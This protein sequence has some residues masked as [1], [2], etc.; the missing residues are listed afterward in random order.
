LARVK[1]DVAPALILNI[2]FSSKTIG[3]RGSEIPE[4]KICGERVDGNLQ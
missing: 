2:I 1:D 4:K 3:L